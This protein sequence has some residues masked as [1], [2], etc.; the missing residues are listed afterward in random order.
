MTPIERAE[1]IAAMMRE[2][3]GL[4]LV[5]DIAAQIRAAVEEAL[6]K[7]F[8]EAAQFIRKDYHDQAI[9]R[10]KARLEAAERVCE[11]LYSDQVYLWNED[12][13]SWRKAAGK[14]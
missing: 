8:G 2:Q 1:K 9:S 10:T 7:S 6:E 11:G 14:S 3:G 4:L 12:L 5:S 13:E